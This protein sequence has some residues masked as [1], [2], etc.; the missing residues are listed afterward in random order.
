MMK[1]LSN[2]LSLVATW[3]LV[4]A[5][6]ADYD[7]ELT[8]GYMEFP[9]HYYTGQ[10]GKAEGYLI[11]LI[12][13][14]AAISGY[15]VKPILLPPKRAV[16]MVAAGKVDLWFGLPTIAIYKDRVL[17][18]KSPVEQL[19]LKLYSTNPIT[20]FRG[21]DQLAGKSIVV[22]RGY[23][24]GGL[25]D[26]IKDPQNNISLLQVSDH[27]QGLR[28]L[29]GRK[30]DYLIDYERTVDMVIDKANVPPLY[31]YELSSIDVYLT[32]FRGLKNAE[33]IMAKLEG[34]FLHNPP[35]AAKGR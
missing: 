25:I 15:K 21:R 3:L 22:M 8:F 18:S 10:S 12:H 19:T 6:Y 7:K 35:T 5:A 16:R 33:E 31:S 30:M 29:V 14:L 20:D 26:F 1:C 34:A 11:D 13:E 28:V 17:I 32:V 2:T 24:Y 4:A 9:P 27:H 23:T